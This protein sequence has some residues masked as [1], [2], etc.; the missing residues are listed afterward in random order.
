M[1]ISNQL[2][3]PFIEKMETEWQE[4]Y[5]EISGHKG[6]EADAIRP[7]IEQRMRQLEKFRMSAQYYETDEVG[8]KEFPN[9]REA[10]RFL[11]LDLRTTRRK[12]R[13]HLVSKI[14]TQKRQ[15]RASHATSLIA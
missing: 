13:R 3:K 6:E 12:W 10:L 2:L 5:R 9:L 11:K 8:L 14:R 15:E 1:E 7:S 4:L